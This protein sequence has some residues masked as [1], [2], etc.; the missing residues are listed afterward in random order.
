MDQWWAVLDK[1]TGR[2]FST[3]T[4]IAEVLPSSFIALA[5]DGPPGDRIWDE[6]DRSFKN[7]PPT[8]E[9]APIPDNIRRAFRG[10]LDDLSSE[11]KLQL[12]QELNEGRL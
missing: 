5:I 1:N 12:L 10:L 3:G 2:L 8:P 11:Q 4:V 7:P 6:A 9:P